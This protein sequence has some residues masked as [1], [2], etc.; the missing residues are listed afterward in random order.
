ML[1]KKISINHIQ[2]FEALLDKQPIRRTTT[3]NNVIS[4]IFEEEDDKSSNT[5]ID[6]LSPCDIETIAHLMVELLISLTVRL[7]EIRTI[8]NN[9]GYYCF[10]FTKNRL[11]DMNQ[12][13]YMDYDY[14]DVNTKPELWVDVPCPESKQAER[15][16]SSLIKIDSVSKE[17]ISKIIEN[18]ELF[19]NSSRSNTSNIRTKS[20][21]LTH[22]DP[23]V[24]AD[25][26]EESNQEEKKAKIKELPI[27]PCYDLKDIQQII[28]SETDNDEVLELRKEKE[29]ELEIKRQEELR[30]QKLRK[31]K[32]NVDINGNI[33]NGNINQKKNLKL[34]DYHKFTFDSDGNVIQ[35]K[36]K[37][38]ELTTDFTLLNTMIR[39][40]KDPN[41]PEASRTKSRK[42]S[43]KSI[44]SMKKLPVII[45]NAIKENNK[46]M[47]IQLG[48]EAIEPAG[49]NFDIFIPSTGVVIKSVENNK[50]KSG[51]FD[52]QKIFKKYSINDYN[53]ILN[54]YISTQNSNYYKSKMT[55]TSTNNLSL[56]S[57]NN[58]NKMNSLSS[59]DFTSNSP[60]TLDSTYLNKRKNPLLVS[61]FSSCNLNNSS[62]SNR[63]KLNSKMNSMSVKSK[64]DLI[65][66][67]FNDDYFSTLPG[68]N[69]KRENI[70]KDKSHTITIKNNEKYNEVNSFAHKLV[71]MNNWGRQNI[72]QGKTL[73]FRKPAKGNTAQEVDKN[74]IG[75]I[76]RL[77]KNHLRLKSTGDL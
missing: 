9:L 56:N 47:G 62:L 12:I 14:D 15:Q 65:D 36:K 73:Y 23:T 37:Q 54:D 40:K 16:A 24:Q 60:L 70:F 52:F 76:P 55:F 18:K 22:R 7:S 30:L 75:F 48:K 58:I 57:L 34:F 19:H 32:T 29:K 71:T 77:R 53:K 33:I 61:S 25:K 51:D 13:E 8:E 68:Y 67:D 44:S 38:P 42:V 59:A 64:F 17:E 27:T 41:K 5:D 10:E 45:H 50:K 20:I 69:T 11:R 21:R 2:G 6:E 63:I 72:S 4:H 49:N 46:P 28:L 74:I 1:K 3:L 43:R 35:Y 66:T 31:K 26:T 39:E